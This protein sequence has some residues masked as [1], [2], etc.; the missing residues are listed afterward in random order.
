L[1]SSSAWP[2][3]WVADES[4]F[5]YQAEPPGLETLGTGKS[6]GPAKTTSSG[7][8]RLLERLI[9]AA[10]AT[11]RLCRGLFDVS[12][13]GKRR[14]LGSRI[15]E[16]AGKAGGNFLTPEIAHTV[17]REAAYREIGVHCNSRTIPR[18]AF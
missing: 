10:E 12:Q 6:R 8:T 5:V 7:L 2:P 1:H 17:R 18:A 9:R 4:C 16:A 11:R 15:S 13:D 14:K 3:G